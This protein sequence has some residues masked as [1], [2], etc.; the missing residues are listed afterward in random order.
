MLVYILIINSLSF[1]MYGIDKYR[2]IHKKYRISEFI[3]LS[4]GFIGGVVGSILGIIVFRHKI[5]SLK[6]KL[7]LL[8]YSILWIYIII[9][10]FI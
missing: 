2:A 7:Y 5:N 9:K 8:L 1:V 3:L 6:F 4:F 10:N